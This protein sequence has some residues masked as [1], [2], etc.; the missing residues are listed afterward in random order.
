MIALGEFSDIAEAQQMNQSRSKMRSSP[1]KAE[2]PY[3]AEA[4]AVYA[5]VSD[6]FSLA[7][8]P[9]ISSHV[10]PPVMLPMSQLGGD[11]LDVIFWM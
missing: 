11:F 7:R 9:P 1:R 8:S 6:T 10:S 3:K 5:C 4:E 2:D